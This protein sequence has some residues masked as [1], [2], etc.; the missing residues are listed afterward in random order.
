MPDYLR[1]PNPSYEDP[2]KSSNIQEL[3]DYQYSGLDTVL[4]LIH[5]HSLP[6]TTSA[7]YRLLGYQNLIITSH[8]QFPDFNWAITIP[9]W[10][11][12]HNTLWNLSRQTTT[13]SS[14]T[15]FTRQLYKS[16]QME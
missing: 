16:Q 9:D 14:M 13:H 7:N 4:Q 6:I 1:G 2:L 11:V 8:Q 10:S 12:L 15:K 5:S 3:G